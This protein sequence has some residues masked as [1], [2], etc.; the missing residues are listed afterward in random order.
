MRLLSLLSLSFL[1]GCPG[2]PAKDSDIPPVDDTNATDDSQVIDTDADD[3]GTPDEE[4]CAPNDA[5]IYP[6]ATETC[7]GIDQNCDDQADEGLTSTYY[8]DADGDGYGDDAKTQEACAAP[9]GYIEQATP[10][11]PRTTAPTPTTTTATAPP[12]L[13]MP[14]ATASPP[15][16]TATTATR[17]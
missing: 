15:A 11:P 13:P 17:R 1:I 16:T 9:A 4:D 12:A 3:D 5:T 14:T 10:A 6:G 8:L 7:D 2:G